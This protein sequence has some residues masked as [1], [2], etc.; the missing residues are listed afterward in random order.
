MARDG[1]GF[2]HKVHWD[3]KNASL[4]TLGETDEQK[5]HLQMSLSTS[6]VAVQAVRIGRSHVRDNQTGSEPAHRAR[7]YTTGSRRFLARRSG[8]CN[9]FVLIRPGVIGTCL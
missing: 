7:S 6:V 5:V 4:S 9:F 2:W 8:Y 1:K 3:G